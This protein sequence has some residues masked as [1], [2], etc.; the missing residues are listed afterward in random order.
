MR[1]RAVLFCGLA[2]SLAGPLR[3]L[4]GQEGLTAAAERVRGAWLAHDVRTIV[5]G[6]PGVTLRIPGAD[7]SAAI[8]PG[9]AGELLSRY[10]QNAVERSTEV[11]VVRE[12]EAGQGFVELI[13]RYVVRGTSEAR[14]ER[15][16]VGIR[17]VAGGRW[18]V[19]EL[20][21]GR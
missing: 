12:V 2:L 7:P 14:E 5:A 6:S 10:L 11:S 16:Y 20:R 19:V 1:S 4:A 13:R 17:T 21:T 3:N 8:S 15:I 9:Q 18:V